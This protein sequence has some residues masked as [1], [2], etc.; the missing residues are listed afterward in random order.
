MKEK[1]R[2]E[3]DAEKQWQVVDSAFELI[4]NRQNVTLRYQT[5]FDVFHVLVISDFGKRVA[6]WLEKSFTRVA[7]RICSQVEQINSDRVAVF[8][9]EYAE[10]LNLIDKV[11]KI[12]IYYDS[13]FALP[14]KLPL[15]A[16]IGH[17]VMRQ[18]MVM[19]AAVDA[20]VQDVLKALDDLRSGVYCD[21]LMIRNSVNSIVRQA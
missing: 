15:S 4:Y 1:L 8:N 12:A 2:S 7:G 17:N 20:I 9:K 21:Y 19:S 5:L 16:L 6:D 14:K 18:A 3:Q 11:Q 13:R 10:Y